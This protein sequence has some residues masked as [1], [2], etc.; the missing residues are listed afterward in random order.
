MQFFFWKMKTSL[1]ILSW[2]LL[3]HLCTFQNTNRISISLPEFNEQPFSAID[4]EK[5][6]KP[7]F[8]KNC[9][10]CH[11]PGGKMY[12]K[13]PFD[14]D[15]TIINHSGSILKRIKDDEENALLKEFI[16]QNKKGLSEDKPH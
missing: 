9:S 13:L 8:V 16:S 4:F 7:I 15:T 14:K 6:I 11:F 2:I 3:V 10:P 5:E 1:I 12:A